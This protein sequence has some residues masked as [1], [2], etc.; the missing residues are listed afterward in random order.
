MLD[1]NLHMIVYV[2]GNEDNDLDKLAIEISKNVE[3]EGVEFVRILPNEDLPVDDKTIN[4]LDVVEGIK[5]ISLYSE[6]DLDKILLPP[7][8]TVHDY[9]LGFQLKYLMKIGKLKKVNII[10]IPIKSQPDYERIKFI[11]RKL[12]AQDIQGS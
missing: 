6:N 1:Y 4:I 7:K 11:L 3:I 10:G 8:G 12:V 9:D 2:F 5:E